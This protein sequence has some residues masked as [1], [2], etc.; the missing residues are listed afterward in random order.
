MA[1]M[2][3]F[4]IHMFDPKTQSSFIVRIRTKIDNSIVTVIFTEESDNENALFK[5]EN[6]LNVDVVVLQKVKF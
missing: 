2:G 3:F 4:P 5:I 1:E 6:K